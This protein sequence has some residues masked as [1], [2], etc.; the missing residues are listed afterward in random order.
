MITK[1]TGRLAALHGDTATLKIDA[2]DYRVL[3]PEFTRRCPLSCLD[4]KMV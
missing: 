4:R 1:I 3:I 2:S